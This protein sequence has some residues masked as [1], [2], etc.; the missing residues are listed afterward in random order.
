MA[1][2]RGQILRTKRA[3]RTLTRTA[4]ESH[5]IELILLGLALLSLLIGLGGSGIR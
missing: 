1:L 4:R 2:T 3:P 5:R